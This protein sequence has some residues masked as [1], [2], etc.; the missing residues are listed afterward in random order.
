MP[1]RHS[2]DVIDALLRGRLVPFLGAGVNLCNRPEQPP[3]TWTKPGDWLPTGAELATYLAERFRYPIASESHVAGCH[4]EQ[5]DLDLAHVSQYGATRLGPGDLYEALEEVFHR[6]YRA[7]DVH[8]FLAS[9]NFAAPDAKLPQDKYLL[10]VSSNYDDLMER[11]FLERGKAF[12]FVFYDPETSDPGGPTRSMFLHQIP[13]ENEPVPIDKPNEYD[14]PFFEE[15]PVVLK[16][17]GTRG[18]PVVITEDHYIDY[19][20]DEAFAKLPNRL[21]TRLKNSHLMFLGYSLRDW[22]FRV[23]LR[24]IKRKSTQD[25][26]SWAIVKNVDADEADFWKARA[27]VDILS[28][29]LKEYVAGL[30]AELK[31]R[32]VQWDAPNGQPSK[33]EAPKAKGEAANG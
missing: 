15:R 6:D 23:F 5:A 25:R 27:R 4:H 9:L 20:A 29:D 21:L 16:I 10:I 17:H 33:E 14:F 18:R 11:A 12:D 3:V 28:R 22:N 30:T 7:T 32:P 26:A 24:R 2:A 13:G 8:R 1:D 19:L 31:Q